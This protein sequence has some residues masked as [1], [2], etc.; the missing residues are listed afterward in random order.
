MKAPGVKA[1]SA[2]S[3]YP[4]EVP[5]SVRARARALVR[6][7]AV[8]G[9]GA[10]REPPEGKYGEPP[11]TAGGCGTIPAPRRARRRARPG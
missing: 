10:G 8:G 11:A 4:T 6:V 3:G 2:G 7:I 5:D 9:A 1:R